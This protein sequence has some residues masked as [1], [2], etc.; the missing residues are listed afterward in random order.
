MSLM[1]KI[2][3]GCEKT[4]GMCKHEKIMLA[5]AIIVGIALLVFAFAG[6]GSDGGL[7]GDGGNGGGGG[8]AVVSVDCAGVTTAQEVSIIDYQFSPASVTISAN[9]VVRWTN[10]GNVSHTVTSGVPGTAEAGQEFDTG[11]ISPGSTKCLKF[12]MVGTYTYFCRPHSNVMRDA[13][14]IVQ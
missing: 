13:K 10:N 6:C 4:D 1:C 3:P 12:T 14:V 7:Y 11:L 5:M 9:N 2:A 8:T